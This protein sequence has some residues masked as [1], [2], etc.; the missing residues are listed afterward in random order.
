MKTNRVGQS[1]PVYLTGIMEHLAAELMELAGNVTVGANRRRVTVSDVLRAI[2][3]DDDLHK[4]LSGAAIF[5]G[6]R[7]KNCTAAITVARPSESSQ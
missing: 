1:A 3:C 4:S 6:E 7:I 5:S 2:R